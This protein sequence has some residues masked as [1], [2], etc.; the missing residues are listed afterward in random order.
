MHQ[1]SNITLSKKKKDEIGHEGDLDFP[2]SNIFLIKKRALKIFLWFLFM[3][4]N[5]LIHSIEFHSLV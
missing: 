1:F 3:P 4:F 5:F 2:V